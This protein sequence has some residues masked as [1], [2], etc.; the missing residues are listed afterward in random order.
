MHTPTS[1]LLF[2]V[3]YELYIYIEGTSYVI[4]SYLTLQRCI[5]ASHRAQQAHDGLL[6]CS[7][8]HNCTHSKDNQSLNKLWMIFIF[9]YITAII[10]TDKNV[11]LKHSH[12]AWACALNLKLLER[13]INSQRGFTLPTVNEFNFGHYFKYLDRAC[14]QQG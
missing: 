9:C 10:K 4:C 6:E 5:Q 7:N 1:C 13:D 14:C 2:L 3:S 8:A 11:K 12:L